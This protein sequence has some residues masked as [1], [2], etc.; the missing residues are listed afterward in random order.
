M[1]RNGMRWIAA[2]AALGLALAGCGDSNVFEGQGDEDS[3]QAKKEA[4]L[5]ALNDGDWAEAQKVFEELYDPAKPDSEIAKY[6]AS[7]YVLEAGFD[8][9]ALVDEIA[10]AQDEGEDGESILYGS[11][12]SLFDEN[13]DGVI[14]PAEL[15]SKTLLIGKAM[16]TLVAPQ[17]GEKRI[18]ASRPAAGP[19][20]GATF[21]RG[22]Y[23][24][25]HAVLSVVGELE[26]PNHAGQLILTTAAFD[27]LTDA[28]KQAVIDGVGADDTA[29]FVASLNADL[30]LVFA[31]RGVLVPALSDGITNTDGNDIAQE[32]DNFLVE[33]GYAHRDDPG[34]VVVDGL[35][36]DELRAYLRTVFDVSQPS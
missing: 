20:D 22:L 14:S 17:V 21:Q 9:L 27:A 19:W 31:A 13:G 4:G 12:T 28:Q 1:G 30:A 32:L 11:V 18:A 10:K 7:A 6:L 23:A 25:L 15:S 26:D 33:I 5:E 8:T 2:V 34:A 36:I 3:T 29:A 24:A 16:E 35:E